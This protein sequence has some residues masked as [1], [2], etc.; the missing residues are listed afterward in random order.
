M[1]LSLGEAAAL[2]GAEPETLYAD[3]RLLAPFAGRVRWYRALGG[4]VVID[5]DSFLDLV[6]SELLREG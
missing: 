3:G 2:V 1:L 6:F 5:R 4:R